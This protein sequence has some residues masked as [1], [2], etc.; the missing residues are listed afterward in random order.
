MSLNR[1]L[2]EVRSCTLCADLPLGPKPLL[3]CARSA[4]IL[5]A[6]QAPGRRTHE[7][8]IPFD[9]PSGDRLRDWLGVDRNTFYDA[10]RIAILPLGFCYPGTGKGGDLPPRA[11]CAPQWRS[12]LLAHMPHIRLTVL[13][14]MH[15]QRWHLSDCAPTLTENIHNW[16][17]AW[18]DCIPLP[19]PSP[20]N[21]AWLKRNPVVEREL[22]PALRE[23]VAELLTCS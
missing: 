18:P 15:A 16:Q 12:R 5:I 17:A 7:R 23:R 22:L 11:E 8:G 6:G 4:T 10:R 13:I 14:G 3:Q 20:R 2:S 9:D 21:V 1:L 19:H